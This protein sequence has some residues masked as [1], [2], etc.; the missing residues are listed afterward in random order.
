MPERPYSSRQV[1]GLDPS[2]ASEQEQQV[3]VL[4]QQ[5]QQ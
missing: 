2:Q 1:G 5:G 3:Q 4:L